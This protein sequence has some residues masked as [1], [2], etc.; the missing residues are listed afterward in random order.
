MAKRRRLS[1]LGTFDEPAAVPEARVPPVARIAA[2]AAMQAALQDL[3]DE[4]QHARESG[5]LIVDLPLD[6][7]E[8]QH[9][10]RDRMNFDPEDMSALMASLRDRGQ[11]TAIEVVA[12]ENSRYGLISG[13]RRLTALRKLHEE[14]G[15]GRFLRIKA[16][17]RPAATAPQAY[18]AMVEE[19]EIRSDLSFYERGRLAHEAARLGVFE[20]PAAAVKALFVHVSASK[21]SKI[22]NFVTLHEAVGSALSFPEFIPEK[23]GLALAKAVEKDPS[24]ATE[25]TRRLRSSA[26]KSAAEERLILDRVLAPVR[27]EQTQHDQAAGQGVQIKGG[28]GRIILTGTGVTDQFIAELSQW[29]E[30]KG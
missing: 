5:R 19:N 26:P 2:D 23:L 10:A 13:A 11:Q 24:L 21:R 16:L 8:V 27:P 7:I 6:A 9:L 20:S 22:L 29:L 25:I 17:I 3:A 15:E 30:V 14:T 4:M 12:L 18:L 28:P 1:A